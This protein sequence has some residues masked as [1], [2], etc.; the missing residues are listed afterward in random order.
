MLR[1]LRKHNKWI[2]VVGGSLLMV[3]FLISGSAKQ[4]QPDPA[5]QTV[6]TVRGEK[7]TA[8]QMNLAAREFEALKALVGDGYLENLG[9]MK[10]TTGWFLLSQEAEHAGLVGGSADGLDWIPAIAGHRAPAYLR[11]LPPEDLQREIQAAGSIDAV[12]KRIT[13]A[14]TDRIK[15]MVPG[16]GHQAG[17]TEAEVGT[18]LAKLRGIERM[19]DLTLGAPRL[20]TARLAHE[21]AAELDQATINAVI[22]PAAPLAATL[23]DPTPEELQAQFE[24]F[25]EIA[26]HGAG[27]GFGYLQPPRVKLAWLEVD[28]AAIA[29]SIKLD[30]VAVHKHW[31]QNRATF[32][33]EFAAER[34][35][36]EDILRNEQADS[37]LAEIDRVLKARINQATRTL[38]I[39]GARKI[40]PPD[41]SANKPTLA[42]LAT[43]VVA[44]IKEFSG[45]TIPAP[46]VTQMDSR[47]T[48]VAD[49]ESLP[50]IGSSVYTSATA[51]LSLGQLVARSQELADASDLDLQVGIPFTATPLVDRV[52]NRYYLE[53]LDARR[54]SVPASLDEVRD[55]VVG[56]ARMS[57]AFD[58][59][60]AEAAEFRVTATLQGLDAV[61]TAFEA[62]FPGTDV[63]PLNQISINRSR[64]V[65]FLAQQ[66][67]DEG[68]RNA[69]MDAAGSIPPTAKLDETNV[70]ARTIAKP[71]PAIQS[72]VVAQIVQ[73][74]PVTIE[75]LRTLRPN[76][77]ITLI[78]RERMRTLEA[79]KTFSVDAVTKRL[80]FVDKEASRRKPKDQKAAD[81][82]KPEAPKT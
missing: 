21:A 14:L 80:D 36:I 3:T 44:S 26:P 38:D 77:V 1:T 6:A 9:D 33:G 8:R 57:K 82:S 49:L 32:K 10:D 53:I 70:D 11:S 43:D 17:L 29:S 15:S 46:A 34:P 59:L 7:I 71:I 52:G 23:P 75:V 45:I 61:A 65:S 81:G 16:V 60:S 74:E 54:Q 2:L 64:V 48:P 76:E 63:T 58:R 19:Y 25:R 22:L 66:L 4:F 78:L 12:Y 20:S 41:W 79:D 68:F 50:A 37:I 69:V 18:A 31:Q 47:W 5:K 28:R 51:K 39:D 35:K 24:K 40:L 27:L 30:P 13:D 55:Q 62:R 72:V 67:N 56:D 73:R 42:A